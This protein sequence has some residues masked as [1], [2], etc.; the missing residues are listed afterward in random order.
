MRIKKIYFN[1]MYNQWRGEPLYVEDGLDDDKLYIRIMDV[2]DYKEGA[3]NTITADYKDLND[4]TYTILGQMDFDKRLAI[5]KIPLS[6][7]SNSGIYEVVFSLSFNAKDKEGLLL[8]TPIQTFEIVDTI[9]ADD[10]AIAQDPNYPILVD[11]INQLA[12][13]KVDTSIFPTREEMMKTIEENLN[14]TSMEEILKEVQANGY[15]TLDKLNTILRN[16]ASK[17]DLSGYAKESDLNKFVTNLKF[18]QELDKYV[19]KT[20]MGNYVLK[21]TGKGLSTHDLTDELYE[22]LINLDINNGEVNIDLTEYQKQTDDRLT[23]K[24]KT[25][26]GSINEIKN[27]IP[28]KTSQLQN[29]S[30]YLTE[31]QDLSDYATK[32]ELH[33]HDNKNILD[34]ITQEKID[35]WDNKSDFS[36]S[37]ND[38]TDKP[39]IPTIPDIPTKVSQLEND[40]NYATE[41]FVT[42]KIIEADLG[43]NIDL[44]EYAKT[45]DIPTK[46]SQLENDS[47]YINRTY[48]ENLISTDVRNFL[49]ENTFIDCLNEIVNSFISDTIVFGNYVK[50]FYI[51]RG[52]IRNISD[53]VDLP[54]TI[55]NKEYNNV[56]YISMINTEY[57]ILTTFIFSDEGTL[58]IETPYTPILDDVD[59]YIGMT[60]TE[61]G[62]VHELKG[63]SNGEITECHTHTNKDILDTITSTMINN[64]NNKSDV[65]INDDI[66]SISTT[67]T[68]SNSMIENRLTE[69]GADITVISDDLDSIDARVTYLEDEQ[70]KISAF[71][72][73]Y[74]SLTGKPTIPTKTSDLTN[75]SNFTTKKYVDDKTE[76]LPVKN[77]YT[78][79]ENSIPY[80]REETDTYSAVPFKDYIFDSLQN[81]DMILSVVKYNLNVTFNDGTNDITK[82]LILEGDGEGNGFYED[83]DIVALISYD[84]AEHLIRMNIIEPNEYISYDILRATLSCDTYS[85][86]LQN[87]LIQS[88]NYSKIED[89]P[90]ILSYIVDGRR[91]TLLDKEYYK[92][93]DNLFIWDANKF[94]ERLDENSRVKQNLT[95][96]HV[97]QVKQKDGEGIGFGQHISIDSLRDVYI[98][99][100]AGKDVII[101]VYNSTTKELIGTIDYCE[102]DKYKTSYLNTYKLNGA[103]SIFLA[104]TVKDSVT[105][106]YGN[107]YITD[108]IVYNDSSFITKGELLTKTNTKEYTP[109]E[110]YNPATKKYVDDKTEILPIANKYIVFKDAVPR[111]MENTATTYDGVGGDTNNVYIFDNLQ[112]TDM[113]VSAVRFDLIISFNDGTE[114]IT[115]NITVDA[116]EQTGFS[117]YVNDYFVD[118]NYDADMNLIAV[119][120]TKEIKTDNGYNEIPCTVTKATF[121]CILY[122]NLLKSNVIEDIKYE[123]ITNV[124][125]ELDYLADGRNETLKA[126]EYYNLYDNSFVWD[127]NKMNE[128]LDENSGVT[129]NTTSNTNNGKTIVVNQKD[130]EGIGFGQFVPINN[131]KNVTIFVRTEKDVIIK[132]YNP[133]T[134]EL[135]FTMEDIYINSFRYAKYTIP[136]HKVRDIDNIF[137]AFTVKDIPTD[138]FSNNRIFDLIVTDE[139]T[140]LK[141]KEILTKTNTDEY[142]PTENYHPATKKYVDDNKFS[143]NYEDLNNEPFTFL[144]IKLTETIGSNGT[145]TAYC[146]VFDLE[147]GHRYVGDFTKYD[148]ICLY[149][150][151]S[152]NTKNTLVATTA[153]LSTGRNGMITIM[154]SS[155]TKREILWMSAFGTEQIRVTKNSDG[156]FTITNTLIVP[157]VTNTREF[158]PTSNYHLVHKKYVDDKVAGVN[159]STITGLSTVATS[160]DYNDLTNKPTI[161]SEYTLPTASA[162]QLGGVKIGAGLSINDGV[163]SANGGGTAD[164]GYPRFVNGTILAYVDEDN[165][166]ERSEIQEKIINALDYAL[167]C[168]SGNITILPDEMD[169]SIKNLALALSN[170]SVELGKEIN[171][172]GA[173]LSGQEVSF[174]L[175]ASSN[176]A[177]I[178]YYTTFEGFSVECYL[179]AGDSHYEQ[180]REASLFH[181]EV[182]TV[183]TSGDYNDLTNKPTIPTVT[184]DLTN[185]LKTNYDTAYTHSQ[186]T[187]APSNAQKNSDITKAEIEAKLIGDITT[188]T[189][190][191]YLTEHQDISNL[192]LKTDLHSHSNKTILDNITSDKINSWDNK[193][194]FSGSYNDLT[195]KPTI[196]SIEGLA[197]ETYVN[198]KVAGLVGSAPETLNTLN[199]LATA[200]GNDANFATTI[201]NQI[202]SKVDKVEGKSLVLDTEIA[203]IHE[204]SNKDLLDT[205]EADNVHAH[206]NKSV[207]DTITSD[208]TTKWNKSIPFENTYVSDCDTWLTNGYTKTSTSTTHHPSVCTGADRWGV[209][210]Y[211]SENATNGTGTQ[212]YFPIDGT[213]AG[214]VFTRK[215][216]NRSAGA[217]NLLST[218]DGNYNNLTNKPTIP[219]EYTLPTASA[220]T[221]GG[222]KVGAGLSINDGVLSANGGG[223]ADSVDWSNVQN[224]PTALSQFTNDSGFISSIP[225]EYITE[226]ELNAKGYLTEHQD[227]S[228]KVDKVNGKGLSTNDL[229]DD[230]KANYDSAYEHS[231][232]A[233]APSNAQK[234][235][236]ITK[237][238]I[239]AKLTGNITTHTHSQY[240]T[241]I[242]NEYIT[243]TELNAKGYLTEHQSLEGYAKTTDLH[244]HSNK[245]ILDGISSTNISNWN[246]AYNHSTSTHAPSNAQKNSDITKAE[247]EAKLTGNITTHTHSQYLTEHQ[248]LDGYVKT[249]D[250]STV[251]T[252]G[253]YNDL[254]D[255]PT[256]PSA[257]T[258]PSTHPAS[259]ITGLSKVATSGSY[260]DLSNKPTIPT[261]PNSLPANGGNADTVNNFHI[262]KGTQ[263]QYDAITTKDSNTIYMITG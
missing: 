43:G 39:I 137:I 233:H 71:D 122:S 224:R 254:T 184:N 234:N 182:A 45:S 244:S 150:F 54:I 205:I 259:M 236:D 220:D 243:E 263:A 201:S 80:L 65:T 163:L 13:Y 109:T 38:L 18:I 92:L 85:N 159:A 165:I 84:E 99:A 207:I 181:S 77:T 108:L 215:I 124:P 246:S 72:G 29:D 179:T 149:T 143:K 232:S 168:P 130:S 229:T 34:T 237:A 256:I 177:G 188:H 114:D 28:T 171:V 31:H 203:K 64:W 60:I 152:D 116:D 153:Y 25:I 59:V 164:S 97:I 249:T 133:N 156:T 187:H 141:K 226:T 200:L 126:K 12:E 219:S 3:I 167:S 22:K 258:H 10:E 135:I 82:D 2:P 30:G 193:S 253:S 186:S 106:F 204:H 27:S 169:P 79:F 208:M 216:V 11:L 176:H 119:S 69:V 160:G 61:I 50:Y 111:L 240:L 83:N 104:F 41:S 144:P 138:S 46:V 199:E 148:G 51:L 73:S 81:E 158:T 260:N 14:K 66:N 192:A 32:S 105:D 190:S 252:T 86:L 48:A 245:A 5:F 211:I 262:W 68:Y 175:Y 222:I 125:I 178:Y 58:R 53:N 196:P 212:M 9:E 213:Y 140:F 248:S 180:Q 15:I 139:S 113:I 47:K 57:N 218:F 93:F 42:D 115:E 87:N 101:K 183:A 56:S 67:Q 173:E 255:K 123:K 88:I 191:Q 209:L 19:L 136:F 33:N 112:N 185:T 121:I 90:L 8:K 151:N 23:T 70:T 225:S 21:E 230:L 94:N 107:T 261:I 55:D 250:L 195:N 154:S 241:S 52:R 131:K 194:E 1:R 117:R 157:R 162:T 127:M 257:Y 36:G 197:T 198:N 228:G 7:L 174:G 40:S 172:S 24:D 20:S 227:I 74:N 166:L 103:S 37:Y 120:V 49:L 202:G 91:L 242:P 146:D 189:H 89:V 95:F 210:F 238:E 4:G 251:A 129:Q 118:L 247:I 102:T 76:M 145:I 132:V 170:I 128:R 98:I 155:A 16:Y 63:S 17:A 75:D 62:N 217:W 235:S 231:Q 223:T 44:S 214:R 134:K 6:I 100:N 142:I 26:V 206:S 78:I 147:L 35:D 96:E 239:E 110:D 221:L 161:P